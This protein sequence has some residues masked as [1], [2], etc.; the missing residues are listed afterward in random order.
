[1]CCCIPASVR[2]VTPP[3]PGYGGPEQIL[4]GLAMESCCK[5]V[6]AHEYAHVI[7]RHLTPRSV[8]RTPVGD[9]EIMSKTRNRE[10]EADALAIKILLHRK[11][12]FSPAS[13]A[14]GPLLFF[15]LD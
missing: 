3:L 12:D 6:I 4:G 15:A 9:L 8:A 10:L 2:R 7:A 13:L 14:A 5:F 1:M 11:D